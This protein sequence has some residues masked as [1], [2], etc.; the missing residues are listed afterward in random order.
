VAYQENITMKI[1]L[2]GILV[3]SILFQPALA[4]VSG[5]EISYQIDGESFTGYL[6]YDDAISGTRPGILVVHEWWGHNAHARHSADKLAELGY[7]AFA[8][9]MYG[10][11]KLADHPDDAMQ[12]ATAIK[13][14]TQ[15]RFNYALDLLKKEDSVNANKTAAIGYCMGGGIVLTMAK[16]GSELDGVVSFHGSLGPA[17]ES[18]AGSGDTR[19][20][21]LTGADDPFVPQDQVV[22]FETEMKA[23]SIDYQL[24]SYEGVKHSFTNPDA[25][26]VA[27]KFSMPLA[28]N[29]AADEDSWDR[30]QL[31]FKHLF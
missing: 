29:K 15:Q 8:L 11:G 19:M 1:K 3:L 7:T 22:A 26:A 31:F 25:D 4:E 18:P 20:L 13:A 6:A 23:A 2:Y 9:D 16:L 17:T 12:F 10:T 21:V 5:R 27:E 14:V 24:H 28:Y 30:M